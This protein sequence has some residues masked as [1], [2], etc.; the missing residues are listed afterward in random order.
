[1][2]RRDMY[3]AVG[4]RNRHAAL[5]LRHASEGDVGAARGDDGDVRHRKPEALHPRRPCLDELARANRDRARHADCEPIRLAELRPVDRRP[6]PID[7]VA[8]DVD[9]LVHPLPEDGLRRRRRHQHADGGDRVS[10]HKGRHAARQEHRLVGD[11][12]DHRVLDALSIPQLRVGRVG[13][14]ALRREIQA[15]EL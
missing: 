14:A 10:R 1:M 2:K 13:R 3:V 8:H 11:R 5:H 15:R 6:R 12:V 7:V 4:V 9:A